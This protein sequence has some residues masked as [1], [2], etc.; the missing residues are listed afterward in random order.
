MSRYPSTIWRPIRDTSTARVTKDLLCLHTMVGS[1]RGTWGYFDRL[2]VQVY[3]HVLVGGIWGG[4]V[5]YDMD[6][7]A[8]QIAD[9]DYRAAAN[10]DGNWRVI[11]VETADNAA[12]P[13]A[14]WTPKQCTR[15]V[16]IMVDA[17]RLDGIPLVLVP[18]SKPGR[19]GVCYHRQGCD[20]YRIPGGEL[21]SKAYGK[22]CPTD[23]RI[24]QL[25][26]LIERA[27]NIVNGAPQEDD[28][29]P[30]EHNALYETTRLARATALDVDVLT[31]KV[32][33]TGE[34]LAAVQTA[35]ARSGTWYVRVAAT[36]PVY[37]VRDGLARHVTGVEWAARGLAGTP[38]K[39]LDEV[40]DATL[41][42]QL[43]LTPKTLAV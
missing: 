17:H 21:W 40:T 4:D 30:E 39:P 11:A 24:R 23:P 6:G 34:R 42:A 36:P 35:V 20:P 10:L 7:V 29:T 31:G 19:R 12:R 28:M 26:A 33:A 13:I 16:Q 8:W 41:L 25:P 43:G 18:D 37:E 14:P 22:D 32:N 3:S 5:G 15:N 27:R 1:A 38:V 9:S 2:D